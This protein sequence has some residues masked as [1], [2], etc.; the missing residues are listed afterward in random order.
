MQLPAE[1]AERDRLP[2]APP[3]RKP[4]GSC[5]CGRLCSAQVLHNLG[6]P[7]RHGKATAYPQRMQRERAAVLVHPLEPVHPRD[8]RIHIF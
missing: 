3:A 5:S 2:C 6:V 7:T 1:A 4:V 8:W